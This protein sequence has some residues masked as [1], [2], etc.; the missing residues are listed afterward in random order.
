MEKIKP[1][2]R[3][4]QNYTMSS[5]LWTAK[6]EVQVVERDRVRRQTETTLTQ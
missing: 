2:M 5:L 6:D 3:I 1:L 4:L